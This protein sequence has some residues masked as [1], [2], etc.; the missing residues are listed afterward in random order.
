MSR[1]LPLRGIQCGN[2]TAYRACGAEAVNIQAHLAGSR[3]HRLPTA[4]R[5]L[6]FCRN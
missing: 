6:L 2:S 3:F 5:R 1:T 4:S